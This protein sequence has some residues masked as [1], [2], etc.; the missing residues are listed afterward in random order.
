MTSHKK[1]V[2]WLTYL[3]LSVG[4]VQL[5]DSISAT[6]EHQRTWGFTPV[7]L[8]AVIALVLA[9]AALVSASYF[10]KSFYEGPTRRRDI[11]LIVVACVAFIAIKEA[12]KRA[13]FDDGESRLD[14]W[15]IAWS[16]FVGGGLLGWAI[17]RLRQARS[18]DHDAARRDR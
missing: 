9:G 13:F 3:L 2:P 4:A 5:F 10:Q 1:P 17:S 8:G 18:A 16:Y 15:E 6:V 11:V 7:E 14:A 12:L